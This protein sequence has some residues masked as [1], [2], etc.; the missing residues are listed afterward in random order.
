MKQVKQVGIGLLIVVAAMVVIALLG[1]DSRMTVVEYLETTDRWAEG[2]EIRIAVVADYH[3]EPYGSE[4]SDAIASLKPDLVVIPGDMVHRKLPIENAY[5]LSRELGAKYPTYFVTGNHDV[6]SPH[7]R[8]L[9]Q[10]MRDAGVVVLE[11]EWRDVE[12]E[13]GDILRI[14]GID[15]P[16]AEREEQLDEVFAAIRE[17]SGAG[18]NVEGSARSGAATE[19]VFTL[20]LAHRPERVSSYAQHPI[21]MALVG[22]AHGGQWRIP[23]LLNGLI[24]PHQGLFPKYAGGPYDIVRADGGNLKLIV[25]RGLARTTTWVPRIYNRPEL[26]LVRIQG[27]NEAANKKR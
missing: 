18:S 6:R 25:S 2:S 8:E 17:S 23:G 20:L 3:A 16:L 15:D 19:G 5:A 26:L 27:V 1:I 12:V 14:V 21:D 24:A 11:G 7:Y 10:V 13:E 9:L 22:H 4:L